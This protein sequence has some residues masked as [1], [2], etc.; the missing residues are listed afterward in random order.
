MTRA[1]GF[2]MVEL[3]TVML[4]I[5]ILAAIGVPRLMNRSDG[6]ALS[7]GDA[8]SSALRLA[9][10]TA[11]A[12]RRTV[13][14]DASASAMRLSIAT[15]VGSSACDAALDGV[16]ADDYRSGSAGVTSAGLAGGS[17]AAPK[18]LLFRPDGGIADANGAPINNGAVDIVV[19]G[20]TVRTIRVEGTTGY[21]E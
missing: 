5:G 19:D 9:Q 7:Y 13:C 21:V 14:V 20:R 1:G 3:I 6:A 17:D 11:V 16:G 15:A 12:R 10:K 8:V 4:L 2:T 18:R